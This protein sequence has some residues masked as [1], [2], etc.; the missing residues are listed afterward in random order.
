MCLATKRQVQKMNSIMKGYGVDSVLERASYKKLSTVGT[1]TS[2]HS[3]LELD[4][5]N[6]MNNARGSLWGNIRKRAGK[7]TRG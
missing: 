3:V 5:Y 2:K 4:V 6:H 1:R 7:V